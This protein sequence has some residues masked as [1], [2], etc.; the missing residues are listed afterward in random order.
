MSKDLVS[1]SNT[2]IQQ[3]W[4]TGTRRLAQVSSMPEL[5]ARLLLE[6][7]L[8]AN[9]AFLLAHG[10]ELLSAVQVAQYEQLLERAAQGEPIPYIVGEVDFFGL[11]F[12]VTPAVLIPRPETEQLVELALAWARAAGAHEIVDVGTGS[13]CIA[14]SLAVN[15]PQTAVIATDRSAAALAVARENAAR[16]APRVRFAEGHLLDPLSGPVDLI[17]ANLPYI[18]A[19][20]WSVVADGVKSHEPMLAL[21]GGADGLD[22][23]RNLLQQAP[24]KLRPRGAIFLEIG[25]QQGHAVQRAGRALFPA[26]DIAVLPDYAGRDRF[27]R[28]LA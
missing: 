14:I 26:A 8:Q 3:A 6:F 27:L 9:H 15:L 24:S 13:G 20:E 7:V 10:E 25:W 22:L 19:G 12:V 28:L 5:D 1:L 17:V 23:I 16:L 18:A 21:D 2:S 4:A 11:A